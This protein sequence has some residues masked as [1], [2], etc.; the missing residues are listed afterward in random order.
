MDELM[1]AGI[2]VDQLSG[3]LTGGLLG[4]IFTLSAIGGLL[5]ILYNVLSIIGSWKIYKKLGEPGWKCII[6]F[7]NV[8]V[9]YKYIWNTKMAIW[10][11]ALSLGGALIMQIAAQGTAL[12]YLG[13]AAFLAGWVICIM[14]YHKLSKAFGKGAGF[15][16]GLVLLTGLFQIILG[17]G[18]SQYIGNSCQSAVSKAE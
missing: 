16:V 6:P 17:F 7:Y 8:W 18:K 5:S 4:V 14:G 9:E 10:N 15:T 13:S 3:L 12:Y 1:N 2:T 11:I